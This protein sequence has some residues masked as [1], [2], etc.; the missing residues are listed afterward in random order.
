MDAIR[1]RK[2]PVQSWYFDM[3]LVETYWGDTG[4][5][6][7]YHYT[8]PSNALFGLHEALRLTLLEGLENRWAR[9]ELH[10]KAIMAGLLELGL[11]PF[12]QEGHRLWQINAVKVP[13]GLDDQIMRTR[14]LREYN[15]EIGA[16][17]GPVKGPNLAHRRDGLFGQSLQHFAGVA[18]DGRY[19]ARHELPGQIGRR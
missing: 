13:D 16:G 7:A 15:I 2:V 5:G 17:L 8:A 10:S 19:S 3:S 1:E 18:G 12:A 14:L 11:E 9:H 6:R 4:G